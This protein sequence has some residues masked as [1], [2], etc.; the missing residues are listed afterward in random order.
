MSSRRIAG[1]ASVLRV[2]R[3]VGQERLGNFVC[4]PRWAPP[5]GEER[6]SSKKASLCP[7]TQ[8]ATLLVG[9]HCLARHVSLTCNCA[10][11]SEPAMSSSRIAGYVSLLRVS[12]V[13]GHERLGNF[14][15]PQGWAPPGG[16]ETRSS[17]KAS[18]VFK[19]EH[20]LRAMFNG[21]HAA[22]QHIINMRKKDGHYKV[23]PC[24]RA[25]IEIVGIGATQVKRVAPGYLRRGVA[26]H[27]QL[28][29]TL[30]TACFCSSPAAVV[31]G[32]RNGYVGGHL[33]R[34]QHGGVVAHV[35]RRVRIRRCVWVVL[36][37]LRPCMCRRIG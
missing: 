20:E 21:D 35:T 14:V 13:V 11:R 9:R 27:A 28:A 4:P 5:R 17:T 26:L 19:F 34:A 15:C 3:V 1:I 8:S 2:S 18:F 32:S 25:A 22:V 10:M 37:S 33:G 31:L 7:R 23:P 16:E 29:D 30:P 12:K 36:T 24:M 6:R